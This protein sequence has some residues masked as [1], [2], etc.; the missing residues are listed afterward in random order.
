MKGILFKP[1]KIKAIADSSPDFEWQT[2]RLDG[3]Q[4]INAVPNKWGNE[5]RFN[6]VG[7]DWYASEKHGHQCS[8]KPR[9]QVG[10]VVYIKEAWSPCIVP[11]S[12]EAIHFK[13]G[14]WKH[15]QDDWH[16]PRFL[17]AAN[18]RY[19]IKIKD[20][21]PER[22]QSITEADIGK[23]GCGHIEASVGLRIQWYKELWDSINPKYPWSSNPWVW[24]IEFEKVEKPQ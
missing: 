22:L 21:R 24:R 3:L 7:G 1:W 15:N 14:G 18:A 10:E 16:S 20:V 6:C 5:W 8:I 12:A 17:K 11:M 13:M 9:F 19:F 23:E 4:E 2:R